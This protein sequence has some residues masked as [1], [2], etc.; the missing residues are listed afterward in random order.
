M[1][2]PCSQTLN[3]A[4][5]SHAAGHCQNHVV[6]LIMRTDL[7]VRRRRAH[8][9]Q[10]GREG[11]PVLPPPQ[12]IGSSAARPIPLEGYPR[13]PKET[14]LRTRVRRRQL[15][16]PPRLRTVPGSPVGYNQK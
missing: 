12:V 2:R 4:L 5:P 9:G 6:C 1:L 14:P 8:R 11:T 7:R 15:S 13:G 16:R 3:G 10:A